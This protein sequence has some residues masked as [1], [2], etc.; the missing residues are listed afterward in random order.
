MW[1]IDTDYVTD[2]Y[3]GEFPVQD[4]DSILAG[5]FKTIE[6]LMTWGCQESK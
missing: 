3:N 5:P 4:I 6:S 1:Y 2:F